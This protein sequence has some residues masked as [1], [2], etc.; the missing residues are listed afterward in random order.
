MLALVCSL[1][2]VY[3]GTHGSDDVKGGEL[4]ADR[5]CEGDLVGAVDF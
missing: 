1:D 3:P 5:D 2:E 4:K